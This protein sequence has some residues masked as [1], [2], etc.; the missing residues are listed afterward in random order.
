MPT[1]CLSSQV[2]KT[3][4]TRWGGHTD[5]QIELTSLRIYEKELTRS[6]GPGAQHGTQQCF[7]VLG[8]GY[9]GSRV[10]AELALAGHTVYIHDVAGD[11]V[12]KGRVSDAL[13]D[14]EQCVGSLHK[15]CAVVSLSHLTFARFAGAQLVSWGEGRKRL[16]GGLTHW[17][18]WYV[19]RLS[20][21]L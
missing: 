6:S 7:A 8:C 4:R 14:A 13:G 5:L 20:H 21:R 10:A 9:M 11:A 19:A 16:R 17:R 12:C 3:A 18:A 2:I 1:T 15:L